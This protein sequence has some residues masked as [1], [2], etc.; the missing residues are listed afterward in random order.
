MLINYQN[1]SDHVAGLIRKMIMNG[2]LKP[3]EKVNQ[4]QL[5]EKLNIS[6]GPIREALRMLQNEGLIN[7]E[8]NRGTFV[9]TLSNQDAYEIYTMRA[10]LE[11]KAAELAAPNLTTN[12]FLR[13]EELLG[14]FK[15][16]YQEEDLEREAKCDISFHHTIVL[17]S[18][19]QRLI[20]MHQQLDTQVG[21]MFL[22]VASVVP[23]RAKLVVDIHKHLLD[24]LKSKD[25]EKVKKAFSDHYLHTL[26]DL[27]KMD[28]F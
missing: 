19:H 4:V 28:V 10:L 18:K 8:T 26:K 15:T 7:H 25:L 17:A 11:G 12:D 21:A 20:H 2:T 1:L 16:A 6:R 14:E 23:E 5:A 3:G 27:K 24:V 9:T 22:T 13:L